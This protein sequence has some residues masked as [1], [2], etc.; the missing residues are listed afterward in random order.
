MPFYTEGH[1]KYSRASENN[2]PIGD[3]D[4][5]MSDFKSACTELRYR[6]DSQVAEHHK[7]TFVHERNDKV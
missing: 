2:A 5:V 7:V 3:W 1:D 4:V 6:D